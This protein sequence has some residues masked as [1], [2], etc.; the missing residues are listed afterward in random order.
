MASLGAVLSREGGTPTTGRPVKF[1]LWQDKFDGSARNVEINAVLWPVD[2]EVA[3]QAER[4]AR[5][6]AAAE[7]DNC[8]FEAEFL[9]RFLAQALRDPERPQSLLVLAKELHLFRRG[10]TVQ[11]LQALMREYATLIRTEYP[12]TVTGKDFDG[13]VTEAGNFTGDGQTGS[14]PS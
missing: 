2:P 6:R 8:G 11:L 9:V 14:G 5:E 1:H 12:E 3:A 4:E 7:G 13:M 10:S